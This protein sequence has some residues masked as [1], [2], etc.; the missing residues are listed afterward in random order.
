MVVKA[1]PDGFPVRSSGLR[2][3][4]PD[5]NFAAGPSNCPTSS[6]VI[7]LWMNTDDEEEML[8]RL[9][10][11]THFT[12]LIGEKTSWMWLLLVFLVLLIKLYHEIH[13]SK[14]SSV[15]NGKI[16]GSRPLSLCG[17]R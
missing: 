8:S 10:A 7:Y 6:L 13:V 12:W 3:R 2:E 14:L 5:Q 1:S 15:W 17:V 11:L 9:R 4:S 16:I